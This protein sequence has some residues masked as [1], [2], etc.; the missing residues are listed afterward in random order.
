MDIYIN[1]QSYDSIHL[2]SDWVSRD[3]TTA[4]SCAVCTEKVSK[5]I[6]FQNVSYEESKIN[7]MYVRM[8]K[9]FVLS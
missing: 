9:S 7:C 3:G 6:V 2:M 8:L 5:N 4:L 1:F